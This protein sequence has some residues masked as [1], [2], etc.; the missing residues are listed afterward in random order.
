MAVRPELKWERE[1]KSERKDEHG[2]GRK[3]L[4]AATGGENIRKEQ[5]K[6]IRQTGREVE[7]YSI[8]PS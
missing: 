2:E 5:C 1:R 3:Q 7:K 4:V 6:E 8:S